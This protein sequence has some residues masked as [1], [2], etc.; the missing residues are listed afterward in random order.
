[1]VGVWG[2]GCVCYR[3]FRVL[4]CEQAFRLCSG[5]SRFDLVRSGSECL[6][7]LEV[8]M[9]GQW[10]VKKQELSNYNSSFISFVSVAVAKYYTHHP[11]V[12]KFC[13]LM[14]MTSN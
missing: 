7:R 6:I 10:D 1:M 3:L 9:R 11:N 5:D 8:T 14:N 13:S 2:L 4:N 12:P